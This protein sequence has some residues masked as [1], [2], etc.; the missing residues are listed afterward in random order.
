MLRF[1]RPILD[2]ASVSG[3]PV[4][5]AYVYRVGG[6]FVAHVKVL[7]GLS[8]A[9]LCYI[10]AAESVRDLAALAICTRSIPLESGE[11]LAREV[12][13]EM[14][15]LLHIDVR[16]SVRELRTSVKTALSRR[17]REACRELLGEARFREVMRSVL[18]ILV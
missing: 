14:G 10:I 1:V 9:E 13:E 11:E 18:G 15:R 12:L 3:H 17:W 8:G 4:V 7:Q 5:H 16:K 2:L 6:V